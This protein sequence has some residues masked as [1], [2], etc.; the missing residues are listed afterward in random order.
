MEQ[1]GVQQVAGRIGDTGKLDA[2]GRATLCKLRPW[3]YVRST[4]TSPSKTWYSEGSVD[5]DEK[6]LWWADQC[7]GH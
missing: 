4:F 1:F 5:V 2:V 7:D 3:R 6:V